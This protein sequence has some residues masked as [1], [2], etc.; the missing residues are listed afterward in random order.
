MTSWT[1]SSQETAIRPPQQWLATWRAPQ[2]LWCPAQLSPTRLNRPGEQRF[3]VDAVNTARVCTGV[4]R[5]I[6]R[7]LGYG[8]D[9]S[10]GQ[11]SF[12]EG[13]ESPGSTFCGSRRISAELLGLCGSPERSGETDLSKVACCTGRF[14]PSVTVFQGGWVTTRQQRR[15]G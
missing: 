7:R 9:V 6:P 15:K 14:A 3:R 2:R 1:P 12:A 13:F 5:V 4:F 8:T 10:A 11:R